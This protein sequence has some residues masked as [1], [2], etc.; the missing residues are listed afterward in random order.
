[1]RKLLCFVLTILFIFSTAVLSASALEFCDSPTFSDYEIAEL[2]AGGGGGGGGG[3]SGGSS[4][5]G[6]HHYHSRPR[7][8]LE[9]IV[10]YILMLISLF[11]SAIIFRL[12]LSKYAR[13]SKKLMRM[14]NNTDSAWK[15]KKV[16]SQVK[17]AFMSIQTSWSNL[18][19]TPA[20]QYMTEEL[21][22]SYQTKLAWMKIRKEKNI[23]KH[24]KLIESVPVSVYD[25]KDD[26][27]DFVWF[28]IRGRMVDYTI[29]TETH[30]KVK[31]NTF[32]ENFAEYWKFT[33]N[34]NGNWILA[35][36]LQENE[37]QYIEFQN[38][39]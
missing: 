37:S 32:P 3:G 17:Q 10:S 13:N 21:F 23:L 11:L 16:L 36:I 33:R 29:N 5:G 35:K 7:S 18:D 14:L 22:E 25:D 24:I 31:G 19:M 9:Q 30:E 1:M 39:A 15:Y 26:T 20:K 28:Y 8:L 12:K 2:R 38:E 4:G 27:K 6:T 34:A